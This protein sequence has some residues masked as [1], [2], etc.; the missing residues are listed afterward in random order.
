MAKQPSLDF[1]NNGEVADPSWAE[2]WMHWEH[3]S[4]DEYMAAMAAIPVLSESQM[5]ELIQGLLPTP[6]SW[7]TIPTRLSGSSP[8]L[9]R[10][11]QDIDRGAISSAATQRNSKPGATK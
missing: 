4:Q 2:S 5:C 9:D 7:I 6:S 3:A 8:V 1:G 10:L 11:A